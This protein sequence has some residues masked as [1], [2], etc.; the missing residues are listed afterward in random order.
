MEEKNILIYRGK[1]FVAEFYKDASGNVPALDYYQTLSKK[2]RAEFFALLERL[3]ENPYGEFLP[4][5]KYRIEDKE[6]SIYALKFGINRYFN[7]T[8]IDRRII[9]T[10]GF[11][12]KTQKLGK[13]EKEFLKMAIKARCDYLKRVK[14]GNYYEEE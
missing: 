10:N 11:K 3:A 7:F 2:E 8:T 4:E 14:E 1:Y 12:K 13:R 9:I 5:T 6:N